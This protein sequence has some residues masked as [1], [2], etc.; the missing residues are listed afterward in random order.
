LARFASRINRGIKVDIDQDVVIVTPSENLGTLRYQELHL[1]VGRINDLLRHGG[2]RKLLIDLS[3]RRRVENVILMA[4]VG[5]CR[6]IPGQ[7]AFCGVS[8]EIRQSMK[9][10][11]LLSLWPVY[12]D[13][14]HAL[15]AM[16]NSDDASPSDRDKAVNGEELD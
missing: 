12:A 16:H 1:E 10:G 2:F 9:A 11:K 4:L 5:F 3:E 8:E 15:R 14:A 7:A 6:S 13:L